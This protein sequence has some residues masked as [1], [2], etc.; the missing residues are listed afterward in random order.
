[1][2]GICRAG[3]MPRRVVIAAA[4][5]LIP[6]VAGCEAGTNAPSLQW[7]APTDG[8]GGIIG[9]IT[10]SNAFVLGAPL[11]SALRP[12]QNAAVFFGLTNTGASSDRLTSMTAQIKQRKGTQWELVPLARSVLIPG[13]KVTVN[14]Q[15][16]VLLTGPRP[17]V[18]LEHLLLPVTGGSV[19]TLLLQFQQ[20]GQLT[21][22]VPVMP[23]AQ[24]YATLSPPP[25]PTATP[26]T[27]SLSPSPSG[28]PS[29]TKSRRHHRKHRTPTPSPTP[30]AS[31]S[32]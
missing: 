29:A 8:A 22:N 17:Q 31:A 14:S 30:T 24:Y 23:S 1:M 9:G 6:L 10:V 11:G 12:G 5:A 32:A 15:R 13:G 27:H 19:V 4:V 26:T 21:L 18:I 25:T 28:S 20:A 2:I 16:S 3:T 7:H